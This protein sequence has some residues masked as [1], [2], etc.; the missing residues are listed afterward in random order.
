LKWAAASG[1]AANLT[2]VAT[3]SLSGAAVTVTGLSSYSEMYLTITATSA[4]NWGITLQLNGNTGS[5]YRRME[6]Y[7]GA[8][9]SAI[10]STVTTSMSLS[11]NW[12]ASQNNTINA[13]CQLSNTKTT[14]YTSLI[15]Q[16]AFTSL[17]GGFA[18]AES[19][20]VYEVSEAVSSLTINC[21]NGSFTGGTY[22]IWAI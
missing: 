7:V 21:D 19:F 3:G 4:Q 20:T 16:A 15:S 10:N 2:Q 18:I 6:F 22:R 5:N 17:S 8:G 14:G 1:G 13:S 9:G 11:G 12:Y